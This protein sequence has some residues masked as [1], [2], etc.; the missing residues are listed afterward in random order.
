GDPVQHRFGALPAIWGTLATSGLALLIAGP[1]GIGA[2]IFLAELA[3]R[4]L[5]R[6]LSFLI[7]L[8]AAIPSVVVGLWGLFVLVPW[9]RGVEVTLRKVSGGFFL[10]SGPPI[11]IG[12][13]GSGLLLAILILTIMTAC[14]RVV[15][16]V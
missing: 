11:G 8:L 12:L 9:L 7:E 2:A 1:A 6:P 15:Q 5:E 4:W 10:F 13:L 3:P 14:V 16:R